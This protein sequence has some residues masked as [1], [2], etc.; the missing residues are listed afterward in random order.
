MRDITQKPL[1]NY[2]YLW[3]QSMEIDVNKNQM[4]KQTKK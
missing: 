4:P 3:R 2:M 1:E